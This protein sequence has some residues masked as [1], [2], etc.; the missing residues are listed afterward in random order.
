MPIELADAFVATTTLLGG[1]T[2]SVDLVPGTGKVF[3]NNNA[4][5]AVYAMFAAG[6][7]IGVAVDQTV[8]PPV[9]FYSKNGTWLGS[10]NAAAGTGGFALPNMTDFI[11]AFSTNRIGASA[12]LNTGP[13]TAYGPPAGF[14]T[15][16]M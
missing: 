13:A 2:R 9:T 15:L 1:T 8:S 11:R 16:V 6:D 14:T 5:A 4:S 3:Y 12:R 7:V 10:F